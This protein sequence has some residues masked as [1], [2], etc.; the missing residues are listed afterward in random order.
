LPSIAEQLLLQ[1]QKL[2]RLCD[3]KNFT[4]DMLASELEREKS[5][6]LLCD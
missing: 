3:D 2:F 6:R 4:L 1:E 5:E